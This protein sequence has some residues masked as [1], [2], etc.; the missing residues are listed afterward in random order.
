MMVTIAL[1]AGDI[2]ALTMFGTVLG[3]IFV[4]L[5]IHWIGS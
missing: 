2:V 1:S 4:A 5:L 3:A